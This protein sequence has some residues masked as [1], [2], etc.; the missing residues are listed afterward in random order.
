MTWTDSILL[1]LLILSLLGNCVQYIAR[2]D[3]EWRRTHPDVDR[4][5]SD[6]DDRLTAAEEHARRL[7]EAS[8]LGT[9]WHG[10]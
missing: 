7:R 2:K 8:R 6:V 3:D 5:C 1:V 10:A 9:D 4:D